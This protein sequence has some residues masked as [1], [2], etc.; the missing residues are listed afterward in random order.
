MFCIVYFSSTHRQ[1]KCRQS[2]ESSGSTDDDDDDDDEDYNTLL[3]SIVHHCAE[4]L[5]AERNIY[6]QPSSSPKISTLCHRIE[7]NVSPQPTTSYCKVEEQKVRHSGTVQ[8]PAGD[9]GILPRCKKTRTITSE[10]K[11]KRNERLTRVN[12]SSKEQCD[13][14]IITIESSDTE[15]ESVVEVP[16]RGN[17]DGLPHNNKSDALAIGIKNKRRFQ[18][19]NLG[20]KGLEQEYIINVDGSDTDCEFVLEVESV[21]SVSAGLYGADDIM[22]KEGSCIMKNVCTKGEDPKTKKKKQNKGEKG[23]CNLGKISDYISPKSWTPEMRRFYSDSWGGENFDVSELQKTMSGKKKSSLSVVVL[24]TFI[25]CQLSVTF[26]Y[27]RPLVWVIKMFMSS[28]SHSKIGNIPVLNFNFTENFG[29]VVMYVEVNYGCRIFFQII[30][31][32]GVSWKLTL[33]LTP[34]VDSQTEAKNVT[35]VTPGD[36]VLCF[37]LILKNLYHAYFVG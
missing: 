29:Y 7:R 18:H 20:K 8:S 2:M 28:C 17:S 19:L 9:V 35:T 26:W 1:E 31:L 10:V 15:C 33:C 27:K 16:E 13:V 12:K 36:I 3:Y 4:G 5:P 6:V 11:N 30:L 37:A 25:T 14:D 32:I 34:E 21:P 22:G 23:T 24:Q